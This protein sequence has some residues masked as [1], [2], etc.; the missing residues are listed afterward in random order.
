MFDMHNGGPEKD[1]ERR[2][3]ICFGAECQGGLPLDPL[4]KKAMSWIQAILFI[5]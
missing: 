4:Q 1:R 3:N 5:I 2:R